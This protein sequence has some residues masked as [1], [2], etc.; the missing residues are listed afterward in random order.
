VNKQGISSTLEPTAALARGPSRRVLLAVPPGG[1]SAQLGV[2]RAWL[3]A[4]CG[5]D[6][7]AWAA[8]GT[9]GVVN[10]ALAFYFIE[11]QQ[12]EAFVRR[13]CCAYR[14]LGSA[15]RIDPAP[16]SE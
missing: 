10:D 1:F 4:N 16:F 9:G 8:A 3:D 5:A 13:F 6:G 14:T 11:P 2:M 15:A 7:W 12:A